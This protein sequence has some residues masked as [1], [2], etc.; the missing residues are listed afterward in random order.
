MYGCAQRGQQWPEDVEVGIQALAV[1]NTLKPTPLRYNTHAAL[2]TSRGR[3]AAVKKFPNRVVLAL[4]GNFRLALLG[5]DFA[6]R[7]YQYRR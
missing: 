4:L 7:A 3:G 5:N 2:G 1:S 6:A